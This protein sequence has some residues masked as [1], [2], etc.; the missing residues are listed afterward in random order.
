M[1]KDKNTIINYINQKNP[2]FDNTNLNM[3]YIVIS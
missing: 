3:Y 1:Y 2:I